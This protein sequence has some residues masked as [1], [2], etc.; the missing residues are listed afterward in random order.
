MEILE[1]RERED[2]SVHFPPLG[3]HEYIILWVVKVE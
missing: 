2:S 3:K 1:K